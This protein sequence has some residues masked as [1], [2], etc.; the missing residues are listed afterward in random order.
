MTDA[1]D[2]TGP[3]AVRTGTAVRTGPLPGPAQQAEPGGTFS[4]SPA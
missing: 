1:T 3:V 4:E 2:P